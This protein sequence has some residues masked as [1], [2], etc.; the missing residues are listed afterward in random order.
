M[1]INPKKQITKQYLNNNY[2]EYTHEVGPICKLRHWLDFKLP[3]KWVIGVKMEKENV[4]GFYQ[5]EVSALWK[6]PKPIDNFIG[7]KKRE[8]E[9]RADRIDKEEVGDILYVYDPKTIK[10]RRYKDAIKG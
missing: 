5:A 6:S 1:K 9:L 3:F 7:L 8:T 10:E 4:S 2:A